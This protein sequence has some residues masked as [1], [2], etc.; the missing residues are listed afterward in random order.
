MQISVSTGA[1]KL[2]DAKMREAVCLNQPHRCTAMHSANAAKSARSASL[3]TEHAR[4]LSRHSTWN[5]GR[6]PTCVVTSISFAGLMARICICNIAI[7]RAH[8][9]AVTT[10]IVGMKGAACSDPACRAGDI[11]HTPL[12]LPMSGGIFSDYDS[13][14]ADIWPPCCQDSLLRIACRRAAMGGCTA[15]LASHNMHLTLLFHHLNDR[16]LTDIRGILTATRPFLDVH[17][18]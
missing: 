11:Q 2:I 18:A 14:M 6:Q 5:W 7:E 16:V 1:A 4:R 9:P 17:K 12:Q 8:V 13:V 10:W 15:K 3:L